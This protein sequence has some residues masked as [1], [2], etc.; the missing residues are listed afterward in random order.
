[1]LG[2]ID[3][4]LLFFLFR[5]C[6]GSWSRTGSSLFIRVGSSIGRSL[7]L[8][9]LALSEL[10]RERERGGRGG[11]GRGRRGQVSKKNTQHTHTRRGEKKHK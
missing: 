11:K 8:L 3:L 7:R 6:F 1:M 5:I 4:L 9:A 2:N 10:E